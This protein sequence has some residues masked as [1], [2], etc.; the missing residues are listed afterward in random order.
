MHK[1]PLLI[2]NATMGSGYTPKI[3]PVL[4]KFLII[5]LGIVDGK[6]IGQTIFQFAHELTHLV[7]YYYLG[8]DKTHA[9]DIE[10]SL[11]SAVSIALVKK[12]KPNEVSIF[13][14]SLLNADYQGYKD[15]VKVVK[16]HN[17]SFDELKNTILEEIEKRKR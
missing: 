3:T 11:C 14:K 9:D 12:L 5:K 6:S 7:F 13:T 17:F 15:G 8:L 1:Y 4:D 16:D 10:E 2:D